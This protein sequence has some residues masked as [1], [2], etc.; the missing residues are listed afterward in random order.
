MDGIRRLKAGIFQALGHPTRLAI[1]EALSR[2]E[3]P[4]AAIATRLQTEQANISQHLTVLRSRRLVTT[5]K[6]ANQVFYSV[7]DPLLLEVLRTMRSYCLAHLAEDQ[8]ILTD[9]KS[10]AKGK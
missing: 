2:G 4:V 9:L 3:L 5:R 10:E 7:R 6:H 8:E 1:L